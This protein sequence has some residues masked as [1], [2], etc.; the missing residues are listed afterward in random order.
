[1]SVHIAYSGLCHYHW[2]LASFTTYQPVIKNRNDLSRL[3]GEFIV[4]H[5]LKVIQGS[6]F[7]HLNLK[8]SFMFTVCVRIN[9]RVYFDNALLTE[10]IK[11]NVWC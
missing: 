10:Y 11:R 6:D 1:M 9:G 4:F 8:V 7:L 5:C 2:S 3:K